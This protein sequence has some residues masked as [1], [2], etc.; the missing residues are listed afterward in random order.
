MGKEMNLN[1]FGEIIDRFL[2]ENDVCFLLTM[3]KGTQEVQIQDNLGFGSTIQ[4]F[5]VLNSIKAV[6]KTMQ[7]ELEID[8]AS[9]EWEHTVNVMLT[10]VK[11][12]IL[13]R[14]EK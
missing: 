13:G 10:M 2:T 5:A 9:P 7:E 4:F 1:A 8:T 6:C 3:P 12:D 14:D 11:R